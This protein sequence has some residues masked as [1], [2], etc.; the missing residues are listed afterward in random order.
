MDNPAPTRYLHFVRHGRA[1]YESGP[2]GGRLTAEGRRQIRAAAKRVTQWPIAAIHSS[3]LGRAVESAEI[4]AALCDD[5]P[6]RKTRIL[7]EMIA[8]SWPGHRVP[9]GDQVQGKQ[10]L[11]SVYQRF[12]RPSRTTRHEVI[13]SHGNTIRSLACMVLKT[14][15]T[16]V[17]MMDTSNSAITRFAVDPTGKVKLLSYNETGHV[18]PDLITFV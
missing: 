18:P 4:I 13:V 16:A 5:L 8:T 1:D 6:I 2:F 17:W 9:R 7:R 3:D 14:R 15:L 11:A 12:F 10:Q